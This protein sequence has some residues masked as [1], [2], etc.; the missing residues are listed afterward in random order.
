MK[1]RSS[2]CLPKVGRIRKWLW[3]RGAAA[4]DRAPEAETRSHIA[5]GGVWRWQESRRTEEPS[6]NRPPRTSLAKILADFESRDGEKREII[7]FSF[8]FERFLFLF[9]VLCGERLLL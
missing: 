5:P 8:L 1:N 6:A 4:G 7:Y 9:L 2:K 3:S